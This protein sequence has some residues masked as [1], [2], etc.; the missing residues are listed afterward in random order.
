[1]AANR[2]SPEF[3]REC[4]DYRAGVLYWRGRPASHFRRPADHATFLKKSAGKVAGRKEPRG[5]I[6]V[7]FRNLGHGVCIS[8][9]HIVWAIH[10]G[11]WPEKHIDHIN[12]VRDDNRIENLREVTPAENNRNA[13]SN[14]VF[15]YVAPN[16]S[17]PGTFCA[18]TSIGGEK[19]VHLGVFDTAEDANAHRQ[20]VNAELERLARS[21][22]KKSKTGRK[23]K[24]HQTVSTDTPP[25]SRKDAP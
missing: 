12:R 14:R 1:M 6:C 11:R 24:D 5:Y 16:K 15:P 10:H 25:T 13:S 17:C 21:L 4:F 7:K 8:A 18:Q 22:A 23:R 3:L 2:P 19:V 9:H 20:M